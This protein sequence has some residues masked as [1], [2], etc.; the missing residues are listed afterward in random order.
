MKRAM[1]GLFV[2]AAALAVALYLGLRHQAGNIDSAGGASA[3]IEGTRVDVD[4]QL[5]ARV[6]AVHV[7]EGERVQKGQLIAELDCRQPDARLAQAQAQFDAADAQWAVAQA[8]VSVAEDGAS[9]A[10]QQYQAAQA[11]A[12][13]AR[14]GLDPAINQRDAAKRAA[15]R[16]ETVHQTGGTTDQALDQAKTQAQASSGQL[17]VLNAKAAAA[18]ASARAVSAQ[19]KTAKT[20]VEMAQKKVA[21]AAAQ[22]DAARAGV[23]LA[24]SSVDDCRIEAP[25]P[26]YITTRYVE[27]GELVMPGKHIVTV[28]DIAAVKATFYV[29]NAELDQVHPGSAVRVIADAM[30]ELNF[31]GEVTR[32]SPEAEFTPGNVQTRDDRAR[33]VYAVDIAVANADHKLRPGMP[34]EVH[35]GQ[36]RSEN[37]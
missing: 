1:I 30:P 3:T 15:E 29:A 19:A 8:A 20:Q 4:A 6:L 16:I 13:G 24:E 21:A 9:A 36:A 22:R 27:P 18:Q 14:A 17:E 5:P 10:H 35:H 7:A 11:N 34:I 31:E 2:V 26:G 37:K 32:V 28:V 23:A 25:G 33:L 12:R